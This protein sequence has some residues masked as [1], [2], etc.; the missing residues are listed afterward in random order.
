[1]AMKSKEDISL[2]ST[3]CR[4][5]PKERPKNCC[6]ECEQ[7]KGEKAHLPHL[8]SAI[9]RDDLWRVRGQS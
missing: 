2:A 3:L 5:E 9:G 6:T 7:T 8:L 4:R 1:M